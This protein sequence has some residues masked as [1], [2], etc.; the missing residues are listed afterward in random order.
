MPTVNLA[1]G[2]Q[3]IALSQS[4]FESILQGDLSAAKAM[5]PWDRVKDLFSGGNKSAALETLVD[6]IQGMDAV[7]SF[8]K[9]TEFAVNKRELGAEVL[10]GPANH[11]NECSVAFMIKG[12]SL[13]VIGGLQH[14]QT[15]AQLGRTAARDVPT[16]HDP[17]WLNVEGLKL[18]DASAFVG[19]TD[20]SFTRGGVHKKVAT[21]SDG[22]DPMAAAVPKPRP[23]VPFAGGVVDL[24][25]ASM[26]ALAAPKP[27]STVTGLLRA[28]D[29]QGRNDFRT[30]SAVAQMAAGRPLERYVSTQRPLD[31][32]TPLPAGLNK[33]HAAYATFDRYGPPVIQGELDRT[34]T[35]LTPTQARS[36]LMQ[37]IDMQRVFYKEKLAHNDLHMHNLMTYRNADPECITLKAIDFGKAKIGG[38]ADGCVANLKYLFNRT[39][40]DAGDSIRRAAREN[41]PEA[42]FDTEAVEK[43]YPLHRLLARAGESGES[44]LTTLTA[45]SDQ[46]NSL[47]SQV[48]DQLVKDLAA[49]EKLPPGAR[50]AAVDAAFQKVGILLGA[51]CDQ[52]APSRPA[53]APPA[54]PATE[55]DPN[56]LVNRNIPPDV[57][58][59][60]GVAQAN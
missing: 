4:R 15:L 59:A 42:L 31:P 28:E 27:K 53:V 48:G 32:N 8:N 21:V 55:S 7:Q 29:S 52:A 34:L 3:Q 26:E 36:V 60:S 1:V 41:G 50:D 2:N 45:K 44:S 49:A 23:G 6:S 46:Y 47:L 9:L 40:I 58:L 5:G 10:V 43:H 57:A 38:T 54:A 12:Q 16:A 14:D 37:A 11:E 20:A 17:S 13:K 33:P 18:S 24:L 25:D 22:P 19:V 35:T 56:C 39:A 30:E 51:A